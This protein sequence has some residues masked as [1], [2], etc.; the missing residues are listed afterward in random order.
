ML[1]GE[2]CFGKGGVQGGTSRLGRVSAG[3]AFVLVQGWDARSW[4]QRGL[5]V[6]R[7]RNTWTVLRC[8]PRGQRS[9][10]R[11]DVAPHVRLVSRPVLAGCRHACS[12]E[13]AACSLQLPAWVSGEP[14]ASAQRWEPEPL[15]PTLMLLAFSF[16]WMWEAPGRGVML[17]VL[18]GVVP[19]LPM[20]REG[21]LRAGGVPASAVLGLAAGHR[22]FSSCR[23]SS[24]PPP[25]LRT[26]A[27]PNLRGLMNSSY[28]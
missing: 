7:Q 15:W 24:A 25:P 16:S 6:P 26:P 28:W 12:L 9:A 10:R 22:S 18:L 23:I 2:S 27:L 21:C 3:S 4:S 19:C 17:E 11:R 8:P 5:P 1:S 13:R 20:T 14:L